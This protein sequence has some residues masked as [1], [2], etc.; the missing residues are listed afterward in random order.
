VDEKGGAKKEKKP[1][2]K[3]G[4]SGISKNKTHDPFRGRLRKVKKTEEEDEE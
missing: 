2:Q 3:R 4:A 1:K